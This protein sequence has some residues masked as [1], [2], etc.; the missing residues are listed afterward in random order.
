MNWKMS[1][2]DEANL[3]L[4]YIK[5]EYLSPDTAQTVDRD[6]VRFIS[7]LFYRH[8]FSNYFSLGLFSSISL[9]HQIYIHPSRSINNNWNRI[10]QLGSIFDHKISEMF[11]NSYRLEILANY[12][13][14][15]FEEFL[16]EVR[17]YL[18][19]RLV[20]TDTLEVGLTRGLKLQTVYQLEKED[21]GTFFKEIY[22]QQISRE[23]MSHLVDIGLIY[24]RINGFELTTALNWY[25]RREWSFTEEKRLIRDAISLSPRLNLLYRAS[26]NL[27]IFLSFI[28]RS[29]KDLNIRRQ[30]STIGRFNLRYTF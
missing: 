28:P 21:N 20:F 18:F 6:R 26:R 3:S 22:A 8:R 12:T 17:S 9:E 2:A 27:R 5:Y 29:Y 13:V 4:V 7:D 15:D 19:R 11:R 14:Y 1:P 30:Y 23:L 10:F 16:P 24:L 25:V